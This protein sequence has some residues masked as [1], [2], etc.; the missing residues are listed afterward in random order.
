MRL[1]GANIRD[2]NQLL[3]A[4]IIHYQRVCKTGRSVTSASDATSVQVTKRNQGTRQPP[5]TPDRPEINKKDARESICGV[6]IVHLWLS[7][8]VD[9]PTNS[10]I[11]INPRIEVV[12]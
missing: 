4:V 11:R 2:R 5:G 12:L 1:A 10:Q 3:H 9:Q 6:Y 8:L 7:P